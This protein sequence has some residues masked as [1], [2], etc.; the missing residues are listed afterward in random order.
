MNEFI[1][2]NI[3]T[4]VYNKIVSFRCYLSPSC[5]LAFMI[6][7]VCF[8]QFSN[9]TWSSPDNFGPSIRRFGKFRIP[10]QKPL[11]KTLTF[12]NV[13]LIDFNITATASIWERQNVSI[14]QNN[15]TGYCLD[16]VPLS[17]TSNHYRVWWNN[18]F[19]NSV[20]C[21]GKQLPDLITFTENPK[22]KI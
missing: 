7:F 18:G 22:L 17:G 8:F 15:K 20:R 3:K 21:N 12:L 6:S 5:L 10:I 9:Q 1:N 2:K 14:H 13:I 4:K 16:Q 11:A 19:Q